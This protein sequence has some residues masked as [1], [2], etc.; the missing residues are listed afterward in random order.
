M[1]KYKSII[2]L[3]AILLSL[4]YLACD[5]SGVGP[6]TIPAGTI[7]LRQS[8]FK[9]LN[10]S[11]E[12]FY[13]LW[14]RLDTA[15]M[16]F[17]YSLGKFNIGGSGEITN[18]NG[19]AMEFVFSGDTN[20]LHQ[21][22]VA[23][24]TLEPPNDSN[25][26]P[27]SSILVSGPTTVSVDSVY[28]T[29]TIGGGL[30]LGS[31]GQQL[32]NGANAGFSFAAPTAGYSH[33]WEGIWFCDTTSSHNTFFPSGIRL[34]SGGWYYQGWVVDNSNP[35]DPVYYSTGRFTNP[36]GPDFDG[37]GPCAGTFP[38]YQ[39]PGQDWILSVCPSGTPR[40]SETNKA[41]YGV[42]ITIEPSFEQ[43]GS[44]AFQKPFLK[45]YDI[46]YIQP[47]VHCG[48]SA[49][50]ISQRGAFPSARVRITR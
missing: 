37:A 1:K 7:S 35:G 15:G 49:Y 13:Q 32:L 48:T 18:T 43:S 14:L 20:K 38:P 21:A 19:G 41:N 45:I 2:L 16:I 40:I 44:Q 30:A 12:G 11:V 24:I 23:Y 39:K 31:A 8:N 3:L 26:A 25:P 5:D 17:D 28:A 33:C 9:Q 6:S 47:W 46:P 42:F 27:S 10:N 22:T 34:F 29:M 50:L 4:I 36:Y